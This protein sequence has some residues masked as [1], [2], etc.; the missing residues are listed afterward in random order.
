[1]NRRDQLGQHI[2]EIQLPIPG[3]RE[4]KRAGKQTRDPIDRDA[5]GEFARLCAAH[6]IAHGEHEIAVAERCM[7]GFAQVAN[8]V[9]IDR[10]R[11]ERVL[12]VLPH[13]AHVRQARP[14]DLGSV[15][16]RR[17]RWM[18]RRRLRSWQQGDGFNEIACPVPSSRMVANSKSMMQKRPSADAVCDVAKSAVLVPHAEF[19]QFGE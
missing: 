16:G 13:P 10:E 1:M 6:A 19:F 12:V 8:L 17:R 4:A 7:A 9:S 18:R 11:E 5:A 3:R 14:M 15:R 2:G